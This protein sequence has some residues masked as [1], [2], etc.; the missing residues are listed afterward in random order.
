MSLQVTV[1]YSQNDFFYVKA[2]ESNTMP[3]EIECSNM[4]I[5]NSQWDISCNPT[6]I[7]SNTNQCVYKEL[8][9]NRKN[10][11]TLYGLT[12]VNS[13]SDQKYLDTKR[14]YNEEIRNTINLGI[15]IVLLACF[16]YRN[17]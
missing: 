7:G 4:D 5:T 8:C 12:N 13:G 9:K 10:A 14:K 15:G 17:Y 11:T 1:P 3:T 16:I 2:E 6:N